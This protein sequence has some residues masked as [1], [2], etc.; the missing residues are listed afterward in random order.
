MTLL[1]FILGIIFISFLYPI[2]DSIST[3]ICNWFGSK[4]VKLQIETERAKAEVEE[5]P[6][7]AIGFQVPNEEWEDEDE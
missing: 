1:T 4:S 3:Y 2:L 5:T 7:H 6:V